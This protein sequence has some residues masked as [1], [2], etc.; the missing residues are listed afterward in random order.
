MRILFLLLATQLLFAVGF[1]Q[2]APADTLPGDTLP[3]GTLDRKELLDLFHD[4]TVE[5]ITLHQGR[6]SFSYYSPTGEVR[7]LRDGEKRTGFW[8]VRDDGRIC[9]RM[10]D[11]REKCRIVV[12]EKDG[13]YRKYIVKKDGNHEPVVGYRKFIEGN[14]KNL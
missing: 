7:Q 1:V 12:H 13:S 5:S 8:R 14:P 11:N 3:E 10:E 9:L 6:V 4:R 2:P